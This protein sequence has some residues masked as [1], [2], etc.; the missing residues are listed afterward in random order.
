ME[1][2]GD[3][4]KK[5]SDTKRVSNGNGG[6]SDNGFNTGEDYPEEVGAG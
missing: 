6:G 3:I 1:N 2:L 4:L 5:L